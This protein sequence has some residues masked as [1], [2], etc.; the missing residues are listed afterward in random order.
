MQSFM[1]LYLKIKGNFLDQEEAS[2]PSILL[3]GFCLF[4]QITL[5]KL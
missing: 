3:F 1:P 2:L 4:S 5:M